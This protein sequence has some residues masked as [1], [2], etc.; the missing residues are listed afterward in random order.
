MNK[1]YNLHKETLREDYNNRE[2]SSTVFRD[3]V[4]KIALQR[5]Q[6]VNST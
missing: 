3:D 6:D 5:L 2:L 1:Y 4:Q